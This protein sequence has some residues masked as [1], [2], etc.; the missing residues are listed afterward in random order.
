MITHR[1]PFLLIDKIARLNIAKKVIGGERYI[2]AED[3][4]FQ[5]HFP[6][7]PIYPGVLQIEMVAQLGLCLSYFMING[8]DQIAAG[9]RPVMAMVTKVQHVAFHA[10]IV[11][12]QHIAIY[13]QVIDYD[14][15]MGTMIGQLYFGSQ[16]CSYVILEAYF[17]E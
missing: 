12:K 16:L 17:N 7:N 15:I 11:P 14:G 3:P 8:I 9:S 6:G 10:P 4:I 2:D 1:V 5:G 13:A